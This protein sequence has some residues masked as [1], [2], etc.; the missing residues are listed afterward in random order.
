MIVAP[1]SKGK[2][3]FSGLAGLAMGIPKSVKLDA[4]KL[5]RSTTLILSEK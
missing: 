1:E 2:S 5:D 4:A 3:R